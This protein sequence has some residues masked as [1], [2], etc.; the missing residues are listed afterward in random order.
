[1]FS[2]RNGL[3]QVIAL[4]PLLLKFALDYAIRRVHVN[5]DGLKINSKLQLLFY[6]DDVNILGGSVH[7]IRE[8][9]EAWI[10]ASRLSNKSFE[11]VERVRYLGTKL[12]IKIPFAMK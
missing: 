5:Q 4:L 2:I 7:A 10:V 8:N 9:A 12:T 3:K 1:M 6:A 11:M